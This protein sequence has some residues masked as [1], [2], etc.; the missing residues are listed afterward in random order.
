MGAGGSQHRA[1]RR[2][3]RSVKRPRCAE[4][5]WG[6]G[7]QS[8]C[9]AGHG[10]TRGFARGERW[11]HRHR[12][13]FPEQNKRRR[14]RRQGRAETHPASR[15]WPPAETYPPS[16]EAKSHIPHPT[17]AR[18]TGCTPVCTRLWERL[19]VRRV[20][21]FP[22]P[23]HAHLCVRRRG[24]SA[25]AA[26]GGAARPPRLSAAVM[27][28]AWGG[29][30]REPQRGRPSVTA[31][32]RAVGGAVCGR[33]GQ[34]PR[35]ATGGGRKSSVAARD[36]ATNNGGSLRR[37]GLTPPPRGAP[38]GRAGGARRRPGAPIDQ[39]TEEWAD[40]VPAGGWGGH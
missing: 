21:V 33:G 11:W 3:I 13:A 17:T 30:A 32:R 34:T 26:A 24:A 4:A 9:Q 27:A 28:G 25:T 22:H 39:V 10:R 12:Q 16:D 8:V 18:K 2:R 29:S 36:G 37:E 19:L 15:R 40:G 20:K 5:E 1:L 38:W 7:R 6:A 31:A 35:I 14:P 23:A